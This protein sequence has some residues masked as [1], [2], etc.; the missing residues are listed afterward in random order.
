MIS[1]ISI[2]DRIQQKLE[3]NNYIELE[4][5]DNVDID[6]TA[7]WD[8]KQTTISADYGKP[9]TKLLTD[10]S[11]KVRAANE[12][13]KKYLRKKIGNR[14]QHK[15]NSSAQKWL[16]NAGYFDTKDQHSIIY[17]LVQP[18]KNAQNSVQDEID[19]TDFKKSNLVSKK[20][21][22]GKQQQ[23]TPYTFEKNKKEDNM[24]EA[25]ENIA[26]LRPGKNAQIA[27]K[28]I[29]KKY[30]KNKVRKETSCTKEKNR[31][32]SCSNTRKKIQ[33]TNRRKREKKNK[34]QH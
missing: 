16:K 19:S 10:F 14:S 23:K 30:Q 8:P 33:K 29:S 2:D 12:I 24:I 21:R 11:K 34:K 28:K 31:E 9:K 18:S 3:D 22:R 15:N 1:T 27:A 32:R 6:L 20:E 5:D 26:M 4:S 13:K 7:A 17:P 25:L